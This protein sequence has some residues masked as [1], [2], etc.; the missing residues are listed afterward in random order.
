MDIAVIGGCIIKRIAAWV[1]L[2]QLFFVYLLE[3]LEVVRKKITAPSK[4]QR[5]SSSCLQEFEIPLIKDPMACALLKKTINPSYAINK[6]CIWVARK[7]SCFF[8][9]KVTLKPLVSSKT[10][11]LVE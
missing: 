6:Y 4:L 11:G 2:K 1:L 10:A 8:S 7:L 9:N 5:F 3:K